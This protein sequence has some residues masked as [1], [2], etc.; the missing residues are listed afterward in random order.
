MKA[1][2]ACGGSGHVLLAKSWLTRDGYRW[3]RCWYC[4]E[5][6]EP[7]RDFAS[8]QREARTRVRE[9]GG[10]CPRPVPS[11]APASRSEGRGMR[12]RCDPSIY[13]GMQLQVGSDAQSIPYPHSSVLRSIKSS[14]AAHASMPPGRSV[15]NDAALRA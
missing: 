6:V 11:G 4:G 5:G 10:L 13:R 7:D 8:Y 2:R 1:C 15:V 9:W 14:S 3:E 12:L